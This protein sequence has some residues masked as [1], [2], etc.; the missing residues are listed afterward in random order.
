MTGIRWKRPSL[1]RVD[2]WAGI[3]PSG[4]S[5][6]GVNLQA[7]GLVLTAVTMAV[8]GTERRQVIVACESVSVVLQPVLL[9][10]WEKQPYHLSQSAS[11]ARNRS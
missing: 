10:T 5:M 4:P 2:A 1:S 8:S 7:D 3:K 9:R 11:L 6:I